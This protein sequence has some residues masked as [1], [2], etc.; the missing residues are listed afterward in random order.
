M[1]GSS[2]NKFKEE[3]YDIWNICLKKKER[4]GKKYFICQID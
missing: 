2:P 4:K 3:M 1:D